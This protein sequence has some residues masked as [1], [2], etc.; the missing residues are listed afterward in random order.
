MDPSLDPQTFVRW[1]RDSSPYINAFRGRT[2]VVAFGGEV[3][4]EEQFAKL[5]H[6]IALL[7]SLGVHRSNKD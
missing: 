3:I 7:N 2:F 1:F 4:A 6:D 5:V